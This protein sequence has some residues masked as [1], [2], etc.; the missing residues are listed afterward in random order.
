MMDEWDSEGAAENANEAIVLQ[1]YADGSATWMV[2]GWEVTVTAAGAVTQISGI[3]VNSVA[4]Y[5][6]SS[7][8]AGVFSLYESCDPSFDY[9]NEFAEKME[10]DR[11]R[12]LASMSEEEREAVRKLTFWDNCSF[13]SAVTAY[14]STGAEYGEYCGKVRSSEYKL[15]GF[16]VSNTPIV[17]RSFSHRA[18]PATAR[19]TAKQRSTPDGE[20]S[21]FA[22]TR[23][24]T[25]RARS[26]TRALTIRTFGES[27]R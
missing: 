18:S 7:E 6:A 10:E 23:G 16:V 24:W 22:T 15:F 25:L 21:K 20:G 19:P 2:G 27:Q 26:T 4:E 8:A 13:W 1:R 12:H 3:S 11:R 9:E 17:H 5:D 14:F